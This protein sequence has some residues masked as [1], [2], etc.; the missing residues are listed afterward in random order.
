M[1]TYAFTAASGGSFGFAAGGHQCGR[2]E[3]GHG[4]VII[5]GV[6]EELDVPCEFH[7]DVATRT[8]TLWHNA[9]SGT[10]PPNDGS[11]VAP[12]LNQ[13]V[14]VLGSQAAPVSNV[15][16]LRLGFRDTPPSAFEPHMAPSGSDYGVNRAAALSLVG[17]AGATV[18]NCTF[19]RL[20]N[21]GIFLGGYARGVSIVDSEFAWLG[22]NGIVS[23]G[24]T[25]GGPVPGWGPDGTAGN[26]PRGTQV[27]NNF[28]HELGIVNKQ[29]CFYFQAV[30][31][32]ALIAANVVFNGARHGVQYN[33]D[34]GSGSTLANN[35][36]FNLNRETADTGLFNNWDRLPFTPRKDA[37]NVDEHSGNL[38][39]ANFNSFS[40]FD[41]D[42]CSAYHHMSHNVQVYGAGLK[43]DYSGHDVVFDDDLSIFGNG[44]NQY[45]PLVPGY[46]NDMH[47]CTL[48]A[49]SEGSKLMSN[50]CPNA[51]DWPN[52]TDT[53]VLSPAGLVTICGLSVTEWL[54]LVPGVLS[55]VTVGAIP[56]SLTAEAIVQMARDTLA[57]AALVQRRA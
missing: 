18:A 51:T 38:F 24:D 42:D 40:G 34:F 11:L 50:V 53:V 13:L 25:E 55:N 43:S 23:V 57:G 29:S 47:R 36:M 41:T 5:E 3:A 32:G 14:A 16:F 6:L 39:L 27:L 31:D 9:S 21:S 2:P 44:G 10:P 15:S 33:D 1:G 12:Q 48:L 17:V 8:L 7:F 4:A 35:V 54:A 20:D 46:F 56:A 30:S 37:E 52:I 45:Q 28:A 26:Q 19:S 22:E 49:Q